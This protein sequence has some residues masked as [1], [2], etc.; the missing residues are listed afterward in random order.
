VN[1]LVWD[2]EISVINAENRGYSRREERKDK[3]RR[4]RKASII[5]VVGVLIY[6]FI[7]IEFWI[8]WKMLLTNTLIYLDLSQWKV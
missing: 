6:L 4:Q 2:W 1:L 7:G 3:A 8:G 5:E